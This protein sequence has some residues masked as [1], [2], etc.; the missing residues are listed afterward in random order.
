MITLRGGP[1]FTLGLGAKFN[2]FE[3][4]YAFT[5]HPELSPSHRLSFTARFA[6]QTLVC[7]FTGFDDVGICDP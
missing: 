7:L 2:T 3:V 6:N 4:N 5:S 1:M